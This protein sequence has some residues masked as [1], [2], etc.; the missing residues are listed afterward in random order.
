MGKL[1]QEELV[2]N[3]RTFQDFLCDNGYVSTVVACTKDA[4]F[5]GD[6]ENTQQ[7]AATLVKDAPNSVAINLAAGVDSLNLDLKRALIERTDKGDLLKEIEK[8]L[9]GLFGSLENAPSQEH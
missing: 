4:D 7:V 2:L 5:E 9:K 1:T 3:V 6:S 8:A